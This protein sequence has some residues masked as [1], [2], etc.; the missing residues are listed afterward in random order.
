[1][2][3]CA[4]QSS[5]IEER[6]SE[7]IEGT[8]SVDERLTVEAHL[9]VC[10]PCTELLESIAGVLRWARSFPSV[11][12][13]QQMVSRILD[14]TSGSE[15]QDL[16][17]P[18]V[19]DGLTEYLDGLL[20]TDRV[21]AIEEHLAACS[22]CEEIHATMAGAIEWSR[23]A[24]SYSPPERIVQRILA[25]TLEGGTGAHI[26]CATVEERL[27]GL[28]DG[29]L[30]PDEELAVNTHLADCDSCQEMY[31]NMIAVVR[32]GREFPV[33]EA[34][35]WFATR[36]VANTRT[37]SSLPQRV[38]EKRET[39]LDT[40]GAVGRWILE[41]RTAMTVFTAVLMLGWMTRIAGVPLDPAALSNPGAMYSSVEELA[42]DVYDRSVRLY[43]GVPHALF[44]Q[45]QYRI[46][47]LGEDSQ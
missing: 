29:Q 15:Q 9:P 26:R 21:A 22:A 39:F 38:Q 44:G 23:T 5:K 12:G 31:L 32:W 24:L 35:A 25:N 7:Y 10:V 41:P 37:E 40:L 6:L 42:D 33:F 3:N 14:G 19:R 11:S 28:V 20:P 46:E 13:S 34:P 16:T 1:M 47:Q 17:C 8:L 30:P 4:K 43:Y 45:I 27:F 36:I 2:S 18:T